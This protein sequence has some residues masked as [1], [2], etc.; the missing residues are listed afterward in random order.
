MLKPRT[1]FALAACC[2]AIVAAPHALADGPY[3][4]TTTV[5]LKRGFWELN[6]KRTYP[7][8]AAEG[9]LLNVRVANALFDDRNPA[10]RPAGFD[11]DKNTDGLIAKLPE[12]VASGVRAFT[13]CL[14]G[15]DPGYKGAL[16]SSFEA[17]GSLRPDS[18]KRAARLIQACDTAAR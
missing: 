6:G 3:H 13:V 14:Q 9:L 12:Y 15:G 10:T 16:C 17:D 7:D 5:G 4:P 1:H 11:A 2:A 18:L 8:A